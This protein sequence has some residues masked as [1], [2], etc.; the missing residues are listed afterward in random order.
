MAPQA[1]KA[2]KVEDT[3]EEAY[4]VHESND[5]SAMLP[6]E[7]VDLAMEETEL[8]FFKRFAEE[9]LL[10][11]KRRGT[12]EIGRGPAI[13]C[14]DESS[15]MSGH[16]SEVARAFCVAMVQSMMKEKRDCVVVCYNGWVTKVYKFS[17]MLATTGKFGQQQPS[18]YAE[19]IIDLAS[20][21]PSGG[22]DF[23][24][25]IKEALK[26]VNEIDNS[27]IVFITDGQD[28]LAG[29]LQ[30][31]LAVAKAQGLRVHGVEIGSTDVDPSY[32]PR[33]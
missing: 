10:T 14:L 7:L 27:D 2:Q 5:I 28:Y 26:W 23:D 17:K 12:R 15:S 30:D 32:P 4:D 24:Q 21:C 20:R 25:A 3:Q 19:A 31:E 18:V 29:D 13:I 1:K 16:Y 6:T 33:S 9:K 22:T 11:V 8:L